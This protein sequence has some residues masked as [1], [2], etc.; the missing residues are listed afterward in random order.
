MYLIFAAGL[1]DI[2]A[3]KEAE[4]SGYDIIQKTDPYSIYL[5]IDEYDMMS[6]SEL[7]MSDKM[8]RIVKEPSTRGQFAPI[9]NVARP[10]TIVPEQA[11]IKLIATSRRLQPTFSSAEYFNEKPV[12]RKTPLP[13]RKSG[14]K[15]QCL[16]ISPYLQQDHP[17]QLNEA[18]VVRKY[19]SGRCLPFCTARNGVIAEK[20]PNRVSN[21]CQGQSTEKA[22]SPNNTI[23]V[24]KG[25]AGD[26]K[27]VQDKHNSS[28]KSPVERLHVYSH[29]DSQ[30]DDALSIYEVYTV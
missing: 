8:K 19:E 3:N 9:E 21:S 22:E 12:F 11:P 24:C 13:H 30:V 4:N 27:E 28:D 17:L 2:D 7:N 16:T 20:T 23:S 15:G 18:K 5:S 10:S 26:E 14:A 25:I 6:N 1:D 29:V